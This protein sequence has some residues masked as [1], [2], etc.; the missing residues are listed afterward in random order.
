MAG[1]KKSYNRVQLFHRVKS[2][3]QK[4]QSVEDEVR[5]IIENLRQQLG[6]LSTE[7][8]ASKMGLQLQRDAHLL[9]L[10]N[11]RLLGAG[12]MLY[13]F[14]KERRRTDWVARDF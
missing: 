1:K 3:A 7:Q 10:I 12:I 6:G 2:Y 9:Y 11:L 5:L 14:P 4:I 13:E 8:K